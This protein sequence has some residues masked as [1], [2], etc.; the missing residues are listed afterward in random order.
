MQGLEKCGEWSKVILKNAG[1]GPALLLTATCQH[2]FRERRP[3]NLLREYRYIFYYKNKD[4]FS[5]VNIHFILQ[6][7]IPRG[8]SED[9]A[10][11]KISSNFLQLLMKIPHE[12]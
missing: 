5:I 3:E 9:I 6:E 10:K 1:N 7:E 12:K 4:T 11:T 2:S 8:V